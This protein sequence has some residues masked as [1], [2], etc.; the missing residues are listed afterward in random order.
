M[1]SPSA[2]STPSAMAGGPSMMRFTHRMAMAVNGLPPAMPNAA[3]SRNS[4]AKPS[5]VLS[6]KRTNLTMLA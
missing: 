5:V 3:V 6:W 4:R 2:G 1:T